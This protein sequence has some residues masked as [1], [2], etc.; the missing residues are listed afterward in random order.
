VIRVE[1][2]FLSDKGRRK[3]WA[4]FRDIVSEVLGHLSTFLSDPSCRQFSDSFKRSVFLDGRDFFVAAD[5]R[6][7]V[8]HSIGS[9]T[10]TGS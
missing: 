6:L 9:A 3:G 4:N 10:S 8:I 7:N 2:L 5:S 1:E